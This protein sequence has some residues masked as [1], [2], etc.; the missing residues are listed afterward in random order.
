M[1]RL[2]NRYGAKNNLHWQDSFKKFNYDIITA[3]CF[4]SAP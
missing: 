1:C 3:P 4:D 2:W